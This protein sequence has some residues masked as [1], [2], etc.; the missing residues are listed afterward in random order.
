MI[1]E[2]QLHPR[3]FF[4]QKQVHLLSARDDFENVLD[5]GLGYRVFEDARGDVFF[6]VECNR[7]QESVEQKR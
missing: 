3:Q 6:L 2:K 4:I 5:V 7:V 1:L